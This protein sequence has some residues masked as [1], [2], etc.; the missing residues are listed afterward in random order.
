MDK[1]IGHLDV[2]NVIRVKKCLDSLTDITAIIV[3]CVSGLLN[4]C[5]TNMMNIL[6]FKLV[7]FQGNL[8]K[9]VKPG[10]S[11]CVLLLMKCRC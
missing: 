1:P 2:I 3:F 10:R 6:N 9:L 5:Y 11:T 7:T 4:D 8:N